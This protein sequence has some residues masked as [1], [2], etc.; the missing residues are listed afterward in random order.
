MSV[1]DLLRM[2]QAESGRVDGVALGL[3]TNNND[4]DGLG[5][6]KLKYP[7]RED[8]QDSFWARIAVTMAGNDRGT[9]FLPEVGDE[10]LVAFDKGDIQHPYVIGAL[11][12]GKDKPP[13]DN[14]DGENNTRRIRSRSGHQI[15]LFD[16]A[17]KETLE[18]ATQGGHTILMDDT[19][20]SAR[21][22]IKDSAGSNTITIDSAKN[23]IT[24]ESGMSLKLKSQSVDIEAGASM[25]I[26]ASG[27]IT[28]QG[29]LVRIN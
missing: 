26:K 24:I 20:G 1:L 21:I 28:I 25:N 23:T 27:T 29:A 13:A 11:W 18:V 2:D 12:N 3:V 6:V 10:V 22:A 17:G 15:T 9:F 16:K 14:A 19:A 4:P 8:G 7:W 5:R